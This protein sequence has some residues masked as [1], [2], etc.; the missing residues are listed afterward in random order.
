M[1]CG[2]GTARATGSA[3]PSS[4]STCGPAG[5][6]TTRSS[7]R[8]TARPSAPASGHGDFERGE[9]L[10]AEIYEALRANPEVFNRSVLLIT[11]DEH[12]GFY[13]HVPPPTGVPAP[14]GV[15]QPGLLGRLASFLLR[16]R[17]TAFDFTMLGVRVPA[18]VVSPYVPPGS[19]DPTVRDHA[20][21]PATVRAL[22]AADQPPLT[23]RDRWAP[24]F[25]E[26]LSL[27]EA[28]TDLPDLL[29]WVAR[30][31]APE[32][33]AVAPP[34]AAPGQPEPPVPGYYRDF[35]ELA[36]MVDREL[37][38]PTAPPTLG[39]RATARHVTEE[40]QDHAETTRA[41]GG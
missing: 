23:E 29:A 13:D 9:S 5:C 27:D 10:I 15:P 17:A 3:R 6:R 7:S 35:V 11:Y 16:R 19:V 22:F 33:A 24:P 14:G 28:R 38:G 39:P 20:S 2:K 37:P 21:V 1:P 31:P 8:T 25:L 40:F 12:G 26:L 34:A 4:P 32:A 41:A 36:T 18:L 30:E